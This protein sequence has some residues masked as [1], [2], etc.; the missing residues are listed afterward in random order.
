MPAM[1]LSE[2]SDTVWDFSRQPNYFFALLFFFFEQPLSISGCVHLLDWRH[3][4]LAGV[5][6]QEIAR[7]L[8]TH[9]VLRIKH[10]R[11]FTPV[12]HVENGTHFVCNKI[13]CM[14][15]SFYFVGRL[16]KLV[17]SLG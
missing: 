13:L 11:I 3:F 15:F 2:E 10:Q 4:K 6:E 1:S 16:R 8:S 14:V 17:N 7:G 12:G 9:L 5:A